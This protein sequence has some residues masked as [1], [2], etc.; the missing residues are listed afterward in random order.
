[1]TPSQLIIETV[2][3]GRT[4]R[5]T[6]NLY[7]HLFAEDGQTVRV[8]AIENVAARTAKEAFRVMEL[9]RDGSKKALIAFHHIPICPSRRIS[10]EQ[11]DEI[12]HRIL[13]AFAAEEHPWVLLE[14]DGK[15]RATADATDNHFHLVLGHPGPDLKALDV[16]GSYAKLEAVAR[17][18]EMDWGVELLTPTRRHK[19]VAAA[20]RSLGREDVAKAVL[21]AMPDDPKDLPRSAMSSRTR[22]RA[23]RHGIDLPKE[24]VRI[25]EAYHSAD[26]GKAVRAALESLGFQLMRGDKEGV[27][28]VVKDDI[29]LGALDRLVRDKRAIVAARMAEPGHNAEPTPLVISSVKEVI[30][31]QEEANVEQAT[32]EV[33]L[34]PPHPEAPLPLADAGEW[35]R[36]DIP[37]KDDQVIGVA[38]ADGP[39]RL[40]AFGVGMRSADHGAPSGRRAERKAAGLVQNRNHSCEPPEARQPGLAEVEESLSASQQLAKAKTDLRSFTETRTKVEREVRQLQADLDKLREDAR[41]GFLAMWSR[42]DRRHQDMINN[43]AAALAEAEEKHAAVEQNVRDAKIRVKELTEASVREKAQRQRDRQPITHVHNV[44]EPAP[45]LAP[46]GW[47]VVPED[48]SSDEEDLPA[49]RF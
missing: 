24:C 15:K 6:E 39:P 42:A 30:S 13:K 17:S 14:H 46:S 7:N 1:L 11:R 37:N 22:A 41:D 34:V 36:S 3:H 25:A 26:S 49:M 5:D 4:G 29:V 23:A 35:M 12:V 44:L 9:I 8:I 33:S 19:A 28:L 31:D 40:Q 2:A 32:S 48:P 10:E 21:A 18:L 43:A 16:K 20:A 45:T 27:W 38:S 47:G